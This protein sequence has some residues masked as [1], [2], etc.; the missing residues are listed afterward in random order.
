[1][2][3]ETLLEGKDVMIVTRLMETDVIKIAKSKLI[4]IA[5]APLQYA[6]PSVETATYSWE[7]HVMMALLT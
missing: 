6:V 4:M 2:G 7:K 3:T 5:R 1:M